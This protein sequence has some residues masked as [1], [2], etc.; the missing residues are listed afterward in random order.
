MAIGFTTMPGT[1]FISTGSS[2][3]NNN[4]V[5]NN[6]VY[7]QP[8][9]SVIITAGSQN[10]FYNNV[11]H[12]N[13]MGLVIMGNSQVITGNTIYSN[14]LYCMLLFESRHW[15]ENNSCYSNELDSIYDEGTA[16]TIVNNTVRSSIC[17]PHQEAAVLVAVVAETLEAVLKAAL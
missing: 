5:R 6:E 2:G 12:D 14:G 1:E 10:Q 7:G 9:R 4:I 11:V 16:S 15:V 17:C 8:S 3:V 13:G